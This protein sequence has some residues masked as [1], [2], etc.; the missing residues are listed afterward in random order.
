M[1]KIFSGVLSVGC[2]PV[3]SVW[4]IIKTLSKELCVQSHD[5]PPSEAAGGSWQSISL[6]L[7]NMIFTPAAG[8]CCHHHVLF[9][10]QSRSRIQS[11]RGERAGE[12]RLLQKSRESWILSLILN[13]EEDGD[14]MCNQTLLRHWLMV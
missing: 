14:Q 6:R 9:L 7:I 10:T 13:H 12:Q 5:I 11:P 4:V 1:L 3:V 8:C 2:V